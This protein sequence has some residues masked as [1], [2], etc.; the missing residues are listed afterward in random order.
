MSNGNLII[1]G[2]GGIKVID[3]NNNITWSLKPE[4]V[5]GIKFQTVSNIVLLPNGNLLVANHVDDQSKTDG[6]KLFEVSMQKKLLQTFSKIETRGTP[7]CM[8]VSKF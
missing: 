2:R 4:D 7:M 5:P 6:L 3:Q 8:A 1:G